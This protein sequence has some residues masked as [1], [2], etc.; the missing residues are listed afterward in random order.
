MI[1]HI[2]NRSLF[3]GALGRQERFAAAIDRLP[4]TNREEMIAL[5]DEVTRA[6]T[7]RDLD[8]ALLPTGLSRNNRKIL[9][10]ALKGF[11][12]IMVASDD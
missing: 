7:P 2:F 11:N 8:E 9:V 4:E 10:K 6:M 3:A 5:L 1:R 12:I